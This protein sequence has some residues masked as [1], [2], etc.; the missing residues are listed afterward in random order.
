MSRYTSAYSSFVDRMVEVS[1]LTSR[2]RSIELSKEAFSKGKEID[3][4]CR[5]AIVLLSSHIEA[6][7]KELG[8]CALDAMHSKNVCRSKIHGAVFYHATKDKIDRIRKQEGPEEIAAKVFEFVDSGVGIWGKSAALPGPINAEIFNKG[9][10]NPKVEKVKKF[11]GRFGYRQMQHD[12]NRKLRGDCVIVL[13]NVDQ[14]VEIRNA[15]AHGEASATR[16]PKDVKNL[17][18]HAKI[19]CRNVDDGFANWCRANLCSIR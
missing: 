14:I 12:L 19:F 7:V 15:I 2:A 6:Y 3:A 8:E 13:S 5:G 10:A 4:L 18:E 11:L 17:V 1:T 16:T 9:F